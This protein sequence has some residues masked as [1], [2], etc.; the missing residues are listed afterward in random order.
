MSRSIDGLCF[1]F[2][3]RLVLSTR[4]TEGTVP[5]A[6]RDMVFTAVVA[7]KVLFFFFFGMA[8]RFNHRGHAGN[9]GK[10][11]RLGNARHAVGLLI[12]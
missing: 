5:I 12:Q 1:S 7:L 6:A 3:A 2:L 8:R 4:L 11:A 9:Q 10:R